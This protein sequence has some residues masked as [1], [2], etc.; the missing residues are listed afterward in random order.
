MRENEIVVRSLIREWL[1]IEQAADEG[2]KAGYAAAA[3]L[4][5]LAGLESQLD[6]ALDKIDDKIEAKSEAV[7][8]LA[9]GLGLSIPTLVKWASKGIEMIIKGY[10]ALASKFSSA[11]QSNKLAWAEKIK[12]A[13]ESFYEKGHHLIEG[14]YAKIVKA[15]FLILCA[16]S[17]PGNISV[18]K[19]YADSSE[20]EA[21]FLKIAKIIDLAVTTVLAV[22]SVTGAIDAIKAAHH[23][24]AAT[25]G[26]LTAVKGAHIATAIAEAI[27]EASRSLAR[28][29]AN[30]GVA[31]ALIADMMKKASEFFEPIKEAIMK[32]VEV[33]KSAAVAAGLALALASGS[34]DKPEASPSSEVTMQAES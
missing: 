8:A 19:A 7:V 3:S 16:A 24:L 17:D 27:G 28:V 29:F 10:V 18:Y 22:Y 13:G 20:G 34:G 23:G 21:A 32:G 33:T 25:E 9:L 1:I 26:V 30:V 2:E 5:G 6:A 14:L 31:A 4:N 11:D 15:V 12:S